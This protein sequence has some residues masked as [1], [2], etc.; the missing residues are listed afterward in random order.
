ME[1]MLGSRSGACAGRRLGAE[2]KKLRF[3]ICNY[4]MGF[5]LDSGLTLVG[6]FWGSCYSV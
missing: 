4:L 5:G 6:V 2:N 1:E 3:F